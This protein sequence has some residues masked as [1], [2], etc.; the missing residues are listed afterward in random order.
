MVLFILLLAAGTV[1]T[2]SGCDG[3]CTD[4]YGN[5]VSCPT[6]NDGGGNGV[7]NGGDD[8]EGDDSGGGHR[9][10]RNPKPRKKR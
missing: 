4:A 8:N 9:F 3:D 2:V 10:R 1:F 5:T 7:V 6:D